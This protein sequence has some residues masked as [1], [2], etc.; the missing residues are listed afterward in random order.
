[1]RS[2]RYSCI[3]EIEGAVPHFALEAIQVSLKHWVLGFPSQSVL[4]L[5]LGGRKILRL[6]QGHGQSIPRV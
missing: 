6:S 1:L 5:G 3:L 2:S 4:E